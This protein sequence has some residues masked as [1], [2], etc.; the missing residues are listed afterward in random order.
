MEHVALKDMP[1]DD[2]IKL[3]L[4]WKNGGKV[5]VFEPAW[6]QWYTTL[7]LRSQNC[8]MRIA[9]ELPS[10]DWSQLDKKWRYLAIDSTEEA[11]VFTGNPRKGENVWMRS[12]DNVKGQRIFLYLH[13]E[14][15]GKPFANFKRGTVPWHESLI[16]RPE[17]V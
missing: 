13:E 3:A 15:T 10:I 4:H 2:F 6:N 11:Y 1:D 8:H 12:S 16:E 17:G 14:L 5:E 7:L 9:P